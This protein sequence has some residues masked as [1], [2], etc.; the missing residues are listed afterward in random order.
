M[1]TAFTHCLRPTTDH[2]LHHLAWNILVT[3]HQLESVYALTEVIY[4]IGI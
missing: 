1:R 2:N 3:L 4:E